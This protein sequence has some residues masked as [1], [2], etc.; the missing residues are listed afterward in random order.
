MQG[1]LGS[2]NVGVDGAGHYSMGGD[3]SGDIFVSPGDPAFWLHHGIWWIWK[4]L[5]L[6]EGLNTMSDTDTF[7]DAPA[8][9]NT[10]LDTLIDIGHAD[11]EMVAMWDLLSTISGPFCYIYR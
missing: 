1:V 7:L 11:G 9:S 2:G 4:N 8:S 6:R 10:T 3:P 5:N